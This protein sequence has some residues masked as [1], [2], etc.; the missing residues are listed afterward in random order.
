MQHAT[1][2]GV[3]IPATILLFLAALGLYIA[4]GFAIRSIPALAAGDTASI[5]RI[6]FVIPALALWLAYWLIFR[7]SAYLR[8]RTLWRELGFVVLSLG[9]VHLSWW[10]RMVAL[11]SRYGI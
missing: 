9:M 6:D 2:K 8:P 3:P 7:V 4:S 5:V 1:N 10:L 11:A